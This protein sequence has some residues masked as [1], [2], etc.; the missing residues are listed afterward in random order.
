VS[1]TGNSI[2]ASLGAVVLLAGSAC[3]NTVH[4]KTTPNPWTASGAVVSG[5]TLVWQDLRAA[6]LTCGEAFLRSAWEQLFPLPG[7]DP[8]SVG[9]A[10]VTRGTVGGASTV[11]GVSVAAL[12]MEI[13][14]AGFASLSVSDASLGASPDTG[15]VISV[16]AGSKVTN[17]QFGPRL[18]P[19]LVALFSPEDV[20][21]RQDLNTP[22]PMDAVVGLH[23]QAS[24]QAQVLLHITPPIDGVASSFTADSGG[25]SVCL[26]QNL[27]ISN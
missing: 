14:I 4:S 5:Q 16:G 25:Y 1:R 18:F 27:K 23:F 10:E 15:T 21:R 17:V 22:N 26:K 8:H 13:G 3:S 19:R 2:A 20:G 6:A 24:T 9:N 11:R 7:S 12:D